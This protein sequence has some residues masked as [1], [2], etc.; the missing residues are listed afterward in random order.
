MSLL[1]LLVL[2]SLVLGHGNMVHPPN[3]FDTNGE[4]GMYEGAQCF[5]GYS[6]DIPGVVQGTSCLWFNNYT[7]V[8]EETLPV[9]MRTFDGY[10]ALGIFFS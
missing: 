10:I 9:Y 6:L 7:F 2:P 4:V 1:L 5:G 8:E 3:W